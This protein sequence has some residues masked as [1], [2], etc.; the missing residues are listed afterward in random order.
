MAQQSDSSSSIAIDLAMGQGVNRIIERTEVPTMIRSVRAV[1][2]NGRVELLE[3]P[4]D[5]NDAQVIVTF[6]PTLPDEVRSPEMAPEDV[7]ERRR[8]LAA[9][10]EDWNVRGM[11]EYDDYKAR[12]RGPRVVSLQ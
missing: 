1:Y 6:L 2:R 11:E 5:V 12:R 9:W 8:K 10:E 3:E 7:A 4:G